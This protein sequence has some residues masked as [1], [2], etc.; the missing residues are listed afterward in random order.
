MRAHDARDLIARCASATEDAAGKWGGGDSR[1]HRGAIAAI[2]PDLE[3][4]VRHAW[5]HFVE[6]IQQRKDAFAVLDDREKQN[7]AF[8][9]QHFARG[10]FVAVDAVADDVHAAGADRRRAD[11]LDGG[12]TSDHQCVGLTLL[13]RSQRVTQPV[14]E[15]KSDTT[16]LGRSKRVRGPVAGVWSQ[17]QRNAAAGDRQ[18]QAGF[19]GCELLREIETNVLAEPAQQATH[20][21]QVL[22][23][24]PQAVPAHG[25]AFNE[26]QMHARR[27][28]RAQLRARRGHVE[29]V[30]ALC[31]TA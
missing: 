4:A 28:R 17:H 30:P 31:E 8:D 11:A 1:I 7:G 15:A 14:F 6:G 16:W 5:R 26:M 29:R 24:R 27:W 12:R 19:H 25:R 3:C 20:A 21:E 23:A 18:T 13:Q 10:V 22:H 9:G 2:T